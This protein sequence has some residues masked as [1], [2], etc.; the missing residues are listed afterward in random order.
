[1]TA[2]EKFDSMKL[3]LAAR[4]LQGT[5]RVR[6]LL[7][8]TVFGC[9]AI[10]AGAADAALDMRLQA[11]PGSTHVTVTFS[12]SSAVSATESG[13]PLLNVGWQFQPQDFDPF[14]S[15]LGASSSGV[16]LFDEGFGVLRSSATGELI[17]IYGVWLQDASNSP[18]IGNERFGVLTTGPM[19]LV[20]GDF[21]EWEGSGSF[22]LAS[23]GLTFGALRAGTTGSVCQAGLCGQ[24]TIAP[25]PEASTSALLIA[26]LAP[27]LWIGRRRR[28]A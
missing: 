15:V 6:N 18:T 8:S 20:A 27:L 21:Y 7:R 17:G 5:N 1:M 14:P 22:D 13:L 19:A 11:D 4:P 12:G 2:H 25:V 16:Q 3:P 9:L 10:V 28:A 24:L 26:G 23:T